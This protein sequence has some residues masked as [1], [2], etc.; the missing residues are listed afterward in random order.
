MMAIGTGRA[1]P[2]YLIPEKKIIGPELELQ[3]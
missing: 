2:L 3:K 1:L